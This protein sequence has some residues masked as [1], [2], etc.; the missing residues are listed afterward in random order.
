MADSSQQMVGSLRLKKSLL[1]LR[2]KAPARLSSIKT[3]IQNDKLRSGV[4]SQLLLKV[5]GGPQAGIIFSKAP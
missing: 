5:L 3:A 1:S 2:K 4:A